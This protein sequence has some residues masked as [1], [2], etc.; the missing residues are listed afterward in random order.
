MP[1]RRFWAAKGSPNAGL[2]ARFHESFART[3]EAWWNSACMNRIEQFRSSLTSALECAAAKLFEVIGD[4]KLYAIAL[5]TSGETDFSYVG[6]SANTE[7]S[8]AATAEKY[9]CKYP[10]YA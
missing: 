5:Y 2:F 3:A 4:E 6:V 1:A 9:S 10:G 7:E 8:L